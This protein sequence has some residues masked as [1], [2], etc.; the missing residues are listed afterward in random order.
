MIIT[1]PQRFSTPEYRG[2]VSSSND[3]VPAPSYNVRTTLEIVWSCLTT[4]FAC[5]W[6]AIHPNVP[7]NGEQPFARRLKIFTIAL[8]APETVIWWATQQWISSRQL[9]RKNRKYKWTQTHGFFAI[10]GGIQICEPDGSSPSTLDRKELE[11][12][13]EDGTITV[14]K[15]EILDRSKGDFLS[16]ALVLLQVSWYVLQ[17]LVR[18]IQHLAITELELVTLGYAILNFITY[19]CWWNK[20]LDVHYPIK[21]NKPSNSSTSSSTTSVYSRNVDSSGAEI[22]SEGNLGPLGH[23]HTPSF[24]S[25]SFTFPPSCS[26]ALGSKARNCSEGDSHYSLILTQP[27]RTLGTLET[28]SGDGYPN[29]SVAHPQALPMLN[30]INQRKTQDIEPSY[31]LLSPSNGLHH[32]GVDSEPSVDGGSMP[33]DSHTTLSP[34]LPLA[35]E[36]QTKRGINFSSRKLWLSLKRV[37]YECVVFMC[38]VVRNTLEFRKLCSS[39]VWAFL[40]YLPPLLSGEHHEDSLYSSGTLLPVKED[41]IVPFYSGCVAATIFGATHCLGWHFDFPTKAEEWL[42][43]ASSSIITFVPICLMLD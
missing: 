35:E 7:G 41:N 22:V 29:T 15:E 10:M 25:C 6:I 8:F 31:S 34:V 11:C 32:V 17:V 16:K 28:P 39:L 24:T 2:L 12:Y 33:K 37:Y 4:I 42:W 26:P 23:H 30:H 27:E 1:S 9:A 21:I 40:D 43:R 20:P 14:S 36:G 5:I 19:F 18:A 13:L 38:W 3:L